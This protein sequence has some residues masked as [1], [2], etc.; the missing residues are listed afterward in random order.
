MAI[1][2]GQELLLLPMEQIGIALLYKIT[3]NANS[4]NATLSI[5]KNKAMKSLSQTYWG[6]RGNY[7]LQI[8]L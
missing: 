8:K 1:K 2:L 3:L 6:L 7:K 5:K 4:P